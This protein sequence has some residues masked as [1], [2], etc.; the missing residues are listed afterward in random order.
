MSP[1]RTQVCSANTIDRAHHKI[2]TDYD[3]TRIE[4][5]TVQ[6]TLLTGLT[7]SKTETDY[8]VTRRELKT[9]QLTLLT[10]LTITL[11]QTMMSPGENFRLFS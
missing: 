7:I 6:L 4:L 11:R 3:V 5:K 10:G 1:G 8:D 2:E 9:V